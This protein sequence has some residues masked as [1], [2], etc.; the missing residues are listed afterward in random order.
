MLLGTRLLPLAAWL[1]LPLL[2][3]EWLTN[4]L[5]TR[6]AS[7][8]EPCAPAAMQSVTTATHAPNPLSGRRLPTVA[9]VLCWLAT[10]FN[11]TL[12]ITILIVS[13]GNELGV[14]GCRSCSCV[15]SIAVPIQQWPFM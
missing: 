13:R 11:H 14:A 7:H 5:A 6:R 9:S 4:L 2:L 8:T 12:H 10:R 1:L 3:A 15:V